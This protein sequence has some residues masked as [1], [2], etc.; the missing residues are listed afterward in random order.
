MARFANAA[1]VI[2]GFEITSP[3]YVVSIGDKSSSY[4]GIEIEIVRLALQASGH[5]L[6]A[7]LAP[8]KRR[9]RQLSQGKIDGISTVQLD[10]VPGLH[11]SENYVGY[12]N[13]AISHHRDNII[14]ESISDLSG[15]SIST[16][17]SA[18][19]HLGQEFMDAIQKS[20]GYFELVKQKSQV[21]MFLKGRVKVTVIDKIIFQYLAKR[22]GADL[23]VFRY[24]P[25]FG[26]G[27]KFRLGFASA[28]IRDGFNRGLATIKANGTLRGIYSRFGIE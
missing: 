3:P 23:S 6:V 11:Y 1:D 9:I 13:F 18:R 22:A 10:Q 21:A 20:P 4:T 28:Q 5:D 19:S 15:Y 27:T 26:G 17:H 7:K 25:I 16:W 24:S 2:V 8:L 12:H 14:L